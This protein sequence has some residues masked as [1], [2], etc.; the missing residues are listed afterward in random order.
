M[1]TAKK[2]SSVL[3]YALIGL[4]LL[5]IPLIGTFVSDEVNWT[6]FDFAFGAVMLVALGTIIGF[7]QTG[8]QT[9]ALKLGLTGLALIAFVFIWGFLATA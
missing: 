5:L 6:G 1:E 7:I 9:R 4:P 8:A 2:K 3:V